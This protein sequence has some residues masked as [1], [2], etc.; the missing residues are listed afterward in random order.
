MPTNKKMRSRSS[1]KSMKGGFIKK[2]KTSNKANE[3]MRQLQIAALSRELAR[4]K[5]IKNNR[6]KTNSEVFRTDAK[7]KQQYKTRYNNLIKH[8]PRA[9]VMWTGFEPKTFN[10]SKAFI[11][12]KET[13]FYNNLNTA[14]NFPIERTTH[15]NRLPFN[16][17]Q[18]GF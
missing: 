12:K 2:I 7:Y 17:P 16:D 11:T 3:Y 4:E 10:N 5:K 9:P 13:I 15:N 6:F 14:R 1:K 18:T 8:T